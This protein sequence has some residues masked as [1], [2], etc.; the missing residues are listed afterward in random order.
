MS[1]VTTPAVPD[2]YRGVWSRTLLQTPD[3]RDESSFVRW[4]QT[5]HWH[6]D[7]R[8]PQAARASPQRPE[9]QQGF[10]GL[11]TVEP[12]GGAE[13]CTWHR[14]LDFQPPRATP[15]AGRIEFDG[16][17]RLIETGIHVDYLEVWERVEGSTGRYT[18]LESH[19]GDRTRLLIAGRFAMR[20]RAR[21]ASWPSGLTTA[22]SLADLV[23][24]HPAQAAA[25]LD[26]EISFGRLAQGRFWV[27]Q[28]TLAAL[29]GGDEACS[30]QRLSE[31]EAVVL[32]QADE[33]RWSVLEWEAGGSVLA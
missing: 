12:Q 32:G 26:F 11:T 23:Q 30:V 3:A 5:S 21:C 20:V 6:A 14:Q 31:G 16:P 9:L 25:L 2:C 29:E 24:R 4:L 27:E 10:C 18:V 19:G 15:D 28:S 33:S 8:I 13:V 7:L 22:D 17:D 1:P